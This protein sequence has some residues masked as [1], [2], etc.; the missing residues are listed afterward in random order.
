M[1]MLRTV[2]LRSC[3]EL[4]GNNLL[5]LLGTVLGDEVGG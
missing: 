3:H 1:T 2:V 4:L 5:K